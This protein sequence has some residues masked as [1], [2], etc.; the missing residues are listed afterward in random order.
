MNYLVDYKRVEDSGSS[1][2]GK[3]SFFVDLTAYTDLVNQLVEKRV[4]LLAP[5]KQWKA[6][7][8]DG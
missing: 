4:S 7:I 1:A 2:Y 3:I 6:W 8:S 5:F